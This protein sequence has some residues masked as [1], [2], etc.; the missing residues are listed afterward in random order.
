[1]PRYLDPKTDIVF[2]KIF[3]EHPRLLK[4]FLNAVLPFPEDRLI[5]IWNIYPVNKSQ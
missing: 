4:S 3:G 5:V 1:M 2:K